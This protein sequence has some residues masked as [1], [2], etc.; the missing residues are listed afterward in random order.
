MEKLVGRN[1]ELSLLSEY[2]KSRRNEFIALYGRRRV[3][4]TFLVR[5]FFKDQFDF[6]VSGVIDGTK[7]E[8]MEAFNTALAEYG[9][10]GTKAKN[11]MEAFTFLGELLRRKTRRMKRRCVVFFDELPCFDTRN[12]R[13][14]RAFGYF[15]NSHASWLDNVFLIICG[16][17][18]SWMIQN[19]INNHGGLHNRI[20]HEMHLQ[21]FDLRQTEQYVKSR[22]G[23]WDHLSILQAYMAMGGIPYYLSLLDFSQSVAD[24]IDRLFF[25]AD[26]EMRKEHKRLFQSLYSN[27]EH[28]IDIINLLAKSKKGLT[29]KEIAMQ[30]KLADNGHL[31]DELENLVNCD[32]VRMYYNGTRRNGGIYQLMD[33]YLLFY[34]QFCKKPTSDIHFW[35]NK[36][37]TPQQNTWYGLAYE[38]VCLWHV[39]KILRALHL[40]AIHTEYYS[41]RSSESEQGAQIDL[42]IDRSDG[43]VTI[44]EIK[45][46]QAA[47]TI[48]KSEYMKIMNR[49]ETFRRETKCRKGI[50]TIMITTYGLKQNEYSSIL[51]N[52]IT[53]KELFL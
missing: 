45:Y 30:L 34:H 16:S 4:K 50:Q 12:S 52:S 2:M 8:Q 17:A 35:R 3:G 11:W 42:V 5:S 14:V 7:E 39:Q 23:K 20:T 33:F 9:H 6:Y 15:W 44:C 51:L 36:L 40:D 26:A 27:P 25:F 43:I 53:L 49:E 28:Y 22:K 46:S 31:G 47:Y 1:R 24:N 13:F 48:T 10:Q 19:V 38:R 29:R 37:G 18:T 21:P 41:W 32:F